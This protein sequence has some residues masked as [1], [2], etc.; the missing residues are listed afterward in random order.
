MIRIDSGTSF[1]RQAANSR[2]SVSCSAKRLPSSVR[3]SRWG[4]DSSRSSSALVR[5]AE[6]TRAS[7]S[8]ESN[9]LETKSTAPMSIPF[10][11]SAVSAEAARKITGID[12]VRGSSLRRRIT[13]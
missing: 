3:P 12:R 6:L 7:S 2:G 5:K 8:T 1:W 4:R 10:A 9:G 11:F 13:S